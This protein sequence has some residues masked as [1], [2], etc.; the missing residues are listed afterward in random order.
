LVQSL[1]GHKPFGGFVR[2]MWDL[3]PLRLACLYMTGQFWAVRRTSSAEERE[4]GS[5]EHLALDRL[6]VVDAALDG[7]G[8]PAGGQA[9]RHGVDV[10][11]QALGEGRGAGQ[12][13]VAG[14]ADPLREVLAGELGGP[15]GERADLARACPELGAAPGSR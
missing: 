2:V 1:L 7:A 8:V 15:D 14:V 3:A 4:S 13:G 10:L 9:G 12:A 5:S 11:F 6:D